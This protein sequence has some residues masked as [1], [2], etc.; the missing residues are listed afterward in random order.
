[1][2]IQSTKWRDFFS[3]YVNTPMR[4]LTVLCAVKVPKLVLQA[5]AS[6]RILEKRDGMRGLSSVGVQSA[7]VMEGGGVDGC[8]GGVLSVRPTH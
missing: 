8:R 3:S 7:A 1:M 4:T 5:L 6:G 2:A